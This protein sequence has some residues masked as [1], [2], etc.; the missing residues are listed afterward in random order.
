MLR[1]LSYTELQNDKELF[2]LIATG[3]EHAYKLL[4]ERHR[5]NLFG[6]AMAFLKDT[7]IA[8][9]V[10]QE[11]FLTIW[12]TRH[13]LPA[14][15]KPADYLFILARNKIVSEFRKKVTAP[16]PDG[17]EQLPVTADLL[18]DHQ[19]ENKQLISLLQSALD[20]MP[21]QRRLVF[22]LSR[23]EGLKYEE[24]GKQLNITPNTVKLHKLQALS[25]I[26]SF[27]R[28]QTIILMIW[29]LF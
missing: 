22:E 24:I 9:D 16:M 28:H 19:L 7:F 26:R 12:K 6:H 13:T 8:Q 11:I 1:G 3:D 20:Q 17:W 27:I 14:V 10:V 21:P 23:K 2:R 15:E 4:L 25:F 18:P 29:V 5:N